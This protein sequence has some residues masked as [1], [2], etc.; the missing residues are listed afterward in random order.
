MLEDEVLSDVIVTCQRYGNAVTSLPY[1]EQI[2]K[3]DD[4]D[5]KKT[6]AY[7]KRETLRRVMTPQAYRFDKLYWAY[8]KAFREEIGIYGSSYTN[9][10]MIDLGETLYFAKGS[11]RNIKITTAEDFE[12]FKALLATKRSAWMK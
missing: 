8:E 7:I 10:M 3:I 9:T 11:D 6:R 5:E 2:F 12:L 4:E 1:N